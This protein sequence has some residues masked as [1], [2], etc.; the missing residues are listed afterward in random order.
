[1]TTATSPADALAQRLFGATLGTLELFSVHLGAELGLHGSLA[2]RGSQTA[3]ELAGSTGIAPRYAREWLQHQAV[4]GLLD[5]ERLDPQRRY[6]LSAEHP[7]VLTAPGAEVEH[8]MFGWSVPSRR[9][10]RRRVR[11]AAAC[12]ARRSIPA[13]ATP[14]RESISLPTAS[15][16]S[17]AAAA[18]ARRPT[19]AKGPTARPSAPRNDHGGNLSWPS[20]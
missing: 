11:P 2:Q 4:A 8:M 5:V 3:D 6:S 7:P 1:M 17:P 19:T 16:F 12:A 9:P 18:T 15:S 13:A 14:P 20:R 10:Q